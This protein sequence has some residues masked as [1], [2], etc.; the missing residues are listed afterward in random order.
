[1]AGIPWL[2]VIVL[3]ALAVVMSIC[4]EADAFVAR[5]LT[6]FSSTAKLAFLV[7]GPMVDLKLIA[8]RPAPSA[9]ASRSGSRP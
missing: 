9:C 5:S 6:Q 3:A 4:S 1:V 2:S 8:L 7:I